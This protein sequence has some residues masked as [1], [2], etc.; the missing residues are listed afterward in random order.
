MLPGQFSTRKRAETIVSG[1]EAYQF[2]AFA[3][4]GI[5]DI[6]RFHIAISGLLA[7]STSSWWPR[8][9]PHF[10]WPRMQIESLSTLSA[11][12]QTATF[13]LVR[14]NLIERL[15]PVAAVQNSMQTWAHNGGLFTSFSSWSADRIKKCKFSY[16]IV[17][18][19][20]VNSNIQ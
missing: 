15:L 7:A 17:N 20:I 1:L 16:Q 6:H 14:I 12:Q 13:S 2:V 8:P 3:S 10:E 19:K 11:E 9:W 4:Y 5:A 18:S